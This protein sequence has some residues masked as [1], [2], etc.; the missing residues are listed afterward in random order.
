MKNKCVQVNNKK[1]LAEETKEQRPLNLRGFASEVK[2]VNKLLERLPNSF[3]G[4]LEHHMKN[5]KVNCEMLCQLTG[6]SEATVTRYRSR[7]CSRYKFSAV[8]LICIAMKLNPIFSY[9]LIRKAGFNFNCSLEH[10]AYQ[11]LIMNANQINIEQINK[12]LVSMGLK[13]LN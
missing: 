4:T 1:Q 11:M 10:T 5:K 12:Y 6:L 2:R 13:P 9:D 3:S 7:D 8:M